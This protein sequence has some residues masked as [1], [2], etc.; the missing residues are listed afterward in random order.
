MKD[1]K[2]I[3]RVRPGRD[4]VFRVIPACGAFFM[5]MKRYSAWNFP[6]HI[7]FNEKYFSIEMERGE[8]KDW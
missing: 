2:G 6:C 1:L 7:Y 3:C 5:L 4:K 8:E